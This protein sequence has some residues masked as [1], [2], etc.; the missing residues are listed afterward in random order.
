M[1]T[2]HDASYID[3]REFRQ[4]LPFLSDDALA[5]E[6][7]TGR[8]ATFV[9]NC[10]GYDERDLPRTYDREADVWRVDWAQ[11]RADRLLFLNWQ[12]CQLEG[13]HPEA[14]PEPS[15]EISHTPPAE[16]YV[17]L[18]A[19]PD[20]AEMYVRGE[21]EETLRRAFATIDRLKAELAEKDKRLAETEARLV[22]TQGQPC[23]GDGFRRLACDLLRQGL[24]RAEAART[25]ASKDNRKVSHAGIFYLFGNDEDA[26]EALVRR[27]GEDKARSDSGKRLLQGKKKRITPDHT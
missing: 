7:D 11:A 17:D 12:V 24:Q 6:L 15:H 26:Q 1:Q 10:G 16:A 23:I 27:T 20:I 3:C 14:L 2:P 19:D 18:E 13:R 4:R 21:L 8:L 25:L 22:A 5:S 9:M